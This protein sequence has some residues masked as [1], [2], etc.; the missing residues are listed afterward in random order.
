M[1]LAQARGTCPHAGHAQMNCR[2]VTG[3][4]AHRLQLLCGGGQGGLD[5]GELA[6]PALFLR[7]VEAVAEVGTDFFQTW[8]LSWVN[9]EER[10]SDT[11]ISCTHGVPKSSRKS[12]ERPSAL[13]QRLD[14]T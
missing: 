3:A 10:A 13:P 6:E 14:R 11:S 1:E 4:T 12:R 9:A 8:H 5:R 7:L 2:G